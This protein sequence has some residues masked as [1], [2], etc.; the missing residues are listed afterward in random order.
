MRVR[1]ERLRQLLREHR[2]SFQRT[3]TWKESTGPDK[4]AKLDRIEEVTSRFP[5]RC[6]AFDQFGPVSIRPCHGSA[7]ALESKP[8]RLPATYTRPHVIRYFHGCSSLGDD[9]LWGVLRRRKATPW[10]SWVIAHCRHRVDVQDHPDFRAAAADFE[11][12]S[13]SWVAALSCQAVSTRT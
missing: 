1:R 2:V 12:Q 11:R 5:H 4:D 13:P 9:Q 7:W 3:R 6:F 10:S 8:T